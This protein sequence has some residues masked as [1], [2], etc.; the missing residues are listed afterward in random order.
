MRQPRGQPASN[1]IQQ[2]SLS[3]SSPW[4]GLVI[5]LFVYAG[6]SLYQINLPGLHYD[7][8]FEA[9]PA[10]Q[11]LLGQPT[12]TFRGSGVML[13]GQLF[14]LMTQDYIGAI[15][16]YLAIPFIAMLGATPAALRVMSI[17]VGVMTLWLTYLL[18]YWLT[19]K[20]RVGLAATLLLAVDPTF[21][22]WNR[23]GI[24]V[25]AV[26][27]T[28]GL[29]AT[30]S[31]L[32]RWQTGATGWSI[33]GAFFFGLGLYAKFLFIW[34]I[35]ALIGA[36][37]LLNLAQ[38]RRLTTAGL[39]PLRRRHT[40]IALVGLAFFIGCW[41]LLLYNFQTGGTWLNISQNALTS[42]YG[43]NNLAF[44]SNLL[45]RIHQFGILLRS[46]ELWYLGRIIA[47]PLP[48]IFF[49]L[50]LIG[51]VLVAILAT[52]NNVRAKNK[53]PPPSILPR[54][55]PRP[56]KVG[57]FPFLVIGLTILFSTGTVSALWLTH[58]A[59]L[60]PWP[61]LAIALGG[62]YIYHTLHLVDSRS[63]ATL[64]ALA[65]LGLTMLVATNLLTVVRYH[66]ALTESGG[67]SSHSD[68]VYD[69]SNWL[70]QHATGEVVAMDWGLAAPV[71]YLT[72]GQVTP[73]EIFGY[74]WESNAELT[75]QLDK[76]I[77]QP[78]SL[79]LWRA[80]AE[81]IFD[82]SQEFKA[83][84]RPRQLVEHIEAA[85]YERSGR[86]ILGVTRLVACGTPD[87][88]PPE[89]PQHCP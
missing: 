12:T 57:L 45:E 29:A 27:A 77:T 55:R 43:V 17:L 73:I 20:R 58:F 40:E 9:V 42:Y 71:T 68:A 59:I 89:P 62:W 36:V 54:P 7:E 61:A 6:L 32:R 53:L 5:I 24:F 56:V 67:L 47:N 18:S 41:P 15:N 50:V 88:V 22:F 81:I 8:A 30:V 72:R 39:N 85:F 28:I 16:T 60:T 4:L 76:F 37:I 82:R 51:V 38:F 66:Q 52:R 1:I 86:P 78:E 26:T 49:G 65:W 33:A 48:L 70:A 13:G 11:L 80:P 31:W 79:Y 10:L 46:S 34:L 21:I 19:G 63:S 64:S 87:I 75:V 84:Y 14:P 74:G 2:L 35:A 83:L 44:G 69:L 23:Q 25:T 3:G